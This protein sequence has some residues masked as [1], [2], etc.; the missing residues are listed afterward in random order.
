MNDN[1]LP[2]DEVLQ[3]VLG[4]LDAQRQ[5]A[6]RKNVAEDAELAATVR[7]FEAAVAAVSGEN[8]GQV[9]DE[10]NNRL[11]ARMSEVFDHAQPE[12]THPT[13]L[14][15]S[16]TTWSWMMHSPISRVAAAVVFVLAVTA[17]TLWFHG[18]GTTPAFA[19]FITPILDAK[20]VKFKMTIVMKG[21]PAVTTTGEMMI[22]DAARSRHEMVMPDGSK[23]VTIDDMSQSKRLILLP[24]TKTAT[25]HTFTNRAKYEASGNKNPLAGFRS[26]MLD[27][28]DK[29]GIK[30]E[31][32]G[33]KQ[34]DGRRAV[35]FH[36]SNERGDM[37]LWGDPKTGMPVRFDI[38]SKDGNIN[39]TVSDFVFNADMD[40]SLFSLEPPAGYTIRYGK[41]DASPKE[42]KDLI[43]MFREYSRLTGTMPD[44][45]DMKTVWKTVWKWGNA[46]IQWERE[47]PE[48]GKVTEEQKHRYMEI[49][50]EKNF[51]MKELQ[52]LKFEITWDNIAPENVRANEEQK[53][54]FVELMLKTAEGKLKNEQFKKEIR[55]VGGDQM[56][57]AMQA[58]M[59]KVAEARAAEMQKSAKVKEA[60]SQ[61][62]MEAQQRV[63][64]GLRFAN[65]LSPA[66]DAHYAGKGVSLDTADTPIFW[67]RPKD[68]KKYRVIYA[69]LLVREAETPPSVS[70]AQPGPV[71][72][73]KKK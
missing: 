55:E 41:I 67:Y 45:L 4:E 54:K 19:D 58:R 29:P 52:Q 1:H 32:L 61:K 31:P 62:F 36:I 40:E 23:T 50:I 63:Q 48:L 42:E 43:A 34:I 25:V 47:A 3:F 7:E 35:G 11:R 37:D 30:R 20:V 15:R 33:E 59:R 68:S 64:R 51:V 56:L 57:K 2:D 26:L 71:P 14:T 60:R 21:P 13:F 18:G 17:I 72:L 66:T 12:I 39:G 24:A 8:P 73:S 53:H 70:D 65:Q 5:A 6:V 28:R 44:S 69:D 46:E 27:A 16:L 10:F 49:L 9:G 22:L 38:T